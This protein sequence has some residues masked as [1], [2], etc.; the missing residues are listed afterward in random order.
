MSVIDCDYLPIAKVEF[1]PKLALLIIRKVSTMAAAGDHATT[2]SETGK[3]T[4]HPIA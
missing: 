1:P 3:N 2:T 4:S